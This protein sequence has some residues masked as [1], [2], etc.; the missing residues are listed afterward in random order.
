VYFPPAFFDINIHFT[1]HLIKKIKLLDHVFLHQM[2]VYERVNDILKSFIINRAYPKGSMLQ[3]YWTEEAI[4]WAL[5][6]AN[7]SNPIGAP[8]SC[9]D[10]RLTGKGTIGKKAITPDPNIFCRLI[11][12]C[13]NRC[14]LCPSN[15][16]ST[17]RCCLETILGV[18]NHG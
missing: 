5:N 2:Y 8:K 3:G 13:C 1:T 16:M 11:S 15:W 10:G 9:Y 6:Y 18:M 4:E 7:L 14:P 12:M 17:R